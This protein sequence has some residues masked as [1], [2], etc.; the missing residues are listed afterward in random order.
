MNCKT[1]AVIFDWTGTLADEYLL[2]KAVCNTMERYIAES[3]RVP[4]DE[5]KKIYQELLDEFVGTWKWYNYPLHG[6][7]LGINWKKAQ[8]ESLSNL[9]LM[10]NAKIVLESL[11]N[12]GYSIYLATN[13]AY[14]V[15]KL[16]VEYLGISKYFD[17]IVSSDIV[18]ATKSEG[19]HLEYLLHNFNIDCSS[20]FFVGD[21]PVEDIQPAKKMGIKTILCKFGGWYYHPS[22]NS[23]YLIEQHNRIVESDYVINNLIELVR[24]IK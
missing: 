16:R 3:R 24:I 23:K 14:E 17:T 8:L 18:K 11:R 2:D 12:R 13:A 7:I 20:S 10:P 21:H 19:K 5:A 6:K 15:I 4:L 9:K 1:K 22:N